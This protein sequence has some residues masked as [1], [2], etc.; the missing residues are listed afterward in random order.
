M[1][2]GPYY[3]RKHKYKE[4]IR[5]RKKEYGYRT[6]GEKI[7]VPWGTVCN[8]VKHIKV[9]AREA[10]LKSKPMQLKKLSELKSQSAIRRYLLITRG[11]RCEGCGLDKWLGKPIPL[12]AHHKDGNKKNNTEKN[13]E[14]ICP[15]CHNFTDN[16]RNK[17]GSVL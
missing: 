9:N 7:G 2:R 5:L 11:H 1:K 3:N 6:I 14:L 16:Y 4:A 13:L 8:W 15:N 10:Y 12:E 17:K